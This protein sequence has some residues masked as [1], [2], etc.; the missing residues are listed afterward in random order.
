MQ[1]HFWG[2][3]ISDAIIFCH[4]IKGKDFRES[5]KQKEWTPFLLKIQVL[6]RMPIKEKTLG[7]NPG[8]L[9]FLSLANGSA[10]RGSE[11]EFWAKKGFTLFVYLIHL[12]PSL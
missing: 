1:K 7:S 8:E 4:S 3:F 9:F 11:S 5:G 10:I 2:T 6:N 12:S